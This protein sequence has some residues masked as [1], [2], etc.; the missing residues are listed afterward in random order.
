MTPASA[1]K[2]F[3]EIRSGL[4]G[5][6][7]EETFIGPRLFLRLVGGASRVFSGQ[8]WFDAAILDGLERAFSRIHF[9][10]DH[11]KAIIPGPGTPQLLFS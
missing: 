7:A 4:H 2:T 9:R 10:A 3:A 1:A 8:G 5:D 11:R 6:P